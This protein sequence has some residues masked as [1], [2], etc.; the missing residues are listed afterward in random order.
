MDTVS[1]L[2]T[3]AEAGQVPER[4]GGGEEL[5]RLGAEAQHLPLSSPAG[6]REEEEQEDQ[7]TWHGEGSCRVTSNPTCQKPAC[8]KQI[9]MQRLSECVGSSEG[10]ELARSPPQAWCGGTS[11]MAG[12]PTT[13]QAWC[14]TVVAVRKDSAMFE[15]TIS[16]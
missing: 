3:K 16:T 9:H 7:Y 15:S 8:R 6:V 4:G 14:S 2:L 12:P 5:E 1:W 10:A 11:Q 13:G